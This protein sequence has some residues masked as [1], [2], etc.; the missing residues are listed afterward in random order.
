MSG[1]TTSELGS[2]KK[3]EASISRIPFLLRSS[4][5]IFIA[6]FIIWFIDAYLGS[7]VTDFLLG[8]MPQNSLEALR[9]L[10]TAEVINWLLRLWIFS[11]ILFLFLPK[12]I[13]QRC[14]DFWS[15]GIWEYRIYVL[16]LF[17]LTGVTTLAIIALYRDH[18]PLIILMWIGRIS[19]YLMMVFYLYLMLRP[20]IWR[21]DSIPLNE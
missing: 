3:I 13:V 1:I 12:Y 6:F 11:V 10:E 9:F 15:M 19:L 20:G 2:S 21:K 14:H 18:I 16:F 8:I 4:V 7:V 17:V 5:V